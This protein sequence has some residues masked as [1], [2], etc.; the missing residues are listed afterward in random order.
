VGNLEQEAVI[1]IFQV[2]QTKATIFFGLADTF[3]SKEAA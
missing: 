3:P 2:F 1:H